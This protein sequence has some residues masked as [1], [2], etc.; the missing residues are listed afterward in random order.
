[1]IRGSAAETSHVPETE[2]APFSK[3]F[4]WLYGNL[5][6]SKMMETSFATLNS[7]AIVKASKFGNPCLGAR[8]SANN[9]V[10][11]NKYPH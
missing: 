2:A 4:V 1:M 6:D 10:D 9:I 5:P 7:N 11:N 3:H 8:K